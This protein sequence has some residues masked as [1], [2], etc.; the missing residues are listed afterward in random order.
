MDRVQFIDVKPP[1]VR[2]RPRKYN[3]NVEIFE[4]RRSGM[5]LMKIADKVGCSQSTVQR[6]LSK[7]DV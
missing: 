5:T 1:G 4:L 3:I 2:G 6:C 7:E